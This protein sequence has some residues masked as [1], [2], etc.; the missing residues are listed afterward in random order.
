VLGFGELWSEI[1][2]VLRYV[3]T[4]RLIAWG[5]AQWTV[6]STLALIIATLAPTFVVVVLGIRAEDS[7][8]VLAPAGIGTVVG[9]VLLSRGGELLDRRRLVEG[10]LM[11]LGTL[12]GLMALAAALWQRM[13][14]L[15][16]TVADA[17]AD[18]GTLGWRTLIGA[19]MLLAVLAGFAFVAIIVPAQTL[20]Q[21]RALPEVRG[22]LFAVQM[23]LSNVASIVPLLALGELADLIGVGRALLLV[24]LVVLGAGVAS[25]RLTGL[26]SA[27]EQADE[28]PSPAA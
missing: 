23:V 20:I 6:G 2:F 7:V 4:D 10:A 21:E 18:P 12:L 22:R 1:R 5:V 19:I 28:S 16:A 17:D 27:S 24:G 13:G 26:D 14:W 8:F 25:T 15:A 11:A 3:R 9:S